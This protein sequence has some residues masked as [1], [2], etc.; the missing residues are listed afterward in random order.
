[1]G[2]LSVFLVLFNDL[3]ADRIKRKQQ[4]TEKRKSFNVIQRNDTISIV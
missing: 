1:M 2:K 4:I 3:L